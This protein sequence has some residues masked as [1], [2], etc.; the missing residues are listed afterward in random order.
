[1]INFENINSLVCLQSISNESNCKLFKIDEETEAEEEENYAEE[2]DNDAEDAEEEPN[3][4]TT[5][6]VTA[7]AM[8]YNALSLKGKEGLWFK[9]HSYNYLRN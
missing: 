5:F 9:K 1:M 8:V 6:N 7:Q 3:R 2:E 4:Y